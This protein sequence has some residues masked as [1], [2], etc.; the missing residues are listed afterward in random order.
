MSEILLKQFELT[1]RNFLKN[2]A[3]IDQ[4]TA[5]AQPNGF[6]NTIHWHIG[7]VLT[8]TE[9]FM[10]GLPKKSTNLP[11][12]YIQL[13]GNGT[14]P[15]DWS[16][17][18][19]SV[20]ELTAQ[21]QEQLSRLKEIEVSSFNQTLNKPFHGLETFG[22]LAGMAIFHEANHLGQI[23]AMKKLILAQ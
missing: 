5:D 10:F 19:P 17:K 4:A 13:F 7:H 2:I 12:L 15:A 1:R 18:V 14:K 23:Q 16:G 22:E 20:E 21:L 6:N 3:S 9:Q 8:V 11:E